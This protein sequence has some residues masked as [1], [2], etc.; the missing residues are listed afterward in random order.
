MKEMNEMNKKQHPGYHSLVKGCVVSPPVYV[1]ARM[2]RRNVIYPKKQI[3]RLAPTDGAAFWLWFFEELNAFLHHLFFLSTGKY[4]QPLNT[5]HKMVGEFVLVFR[6][7]RQGNVRSYWKDPK[8]VILF[9]I[10]SCIW[11]NR[12]LKVSSASE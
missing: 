3:K 2:Y 5:T 8:T 6:R 10:P 4:K 1:Y 7:V 12:S 9:I 11:R